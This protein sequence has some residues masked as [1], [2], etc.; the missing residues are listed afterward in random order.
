MSDKT[1]YFS[2]YF[3][4]E[5]RKSFSSEKEISPDNFDSLLGYY[6]LADNVSCQVKTKR[7]FCRKNHKIGWLGVTVDG[8]E[9]LI[10]GHC[11]KTYF[12]AD[13]RFSLE[14]KRITSELERRRY[15]IELQPYSDNI[16]VFITELD[17]L[18]T[19]L[20]KVRK[21]LS[22]IY[23]TMPNPVLR[24]IDS[25]Q[26]TN[27]WAVNIDVLYPSKNDENQSQWQVHMLST[28]NSVSSLREVISLITRVKTLENVFSD[29]QKINFYDLPTPKLKYY[30][31]ELRQKIDYEKI[32]E[33]LGNETKKFI[34]PR[35]LDLLLF[36]CD[37]YEDKYITVKSI[38]DITDSKVQSN[39]Y[40][41]LRIRRVEERVSKMFNNYMVRSNQN[42]VKYKNNYFS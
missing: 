11:A 17:T 35:N 8:V 7:G 34:V 24:F 15:L 3:E 18:K 25:A 39:A 22:V 12:K 26:R 29:F 14:K 5:N 1:E 16:E 2:N 21:I 13:K 27:D 38:F 30:V 6:E 23:N 32:C 10:G 19:N 4:I 31:D 40:I 9:A 37:E 42:I 36:V 20:I 33:I 28:L 41:S